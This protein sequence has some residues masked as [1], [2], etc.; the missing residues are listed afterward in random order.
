MLKLEAP[1]DRYHVRQCS[2]GNEAWNFI[3]Q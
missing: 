3:V 1:V 2:E